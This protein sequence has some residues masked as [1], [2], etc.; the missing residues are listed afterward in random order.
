MFHL[1]QTRSYSGHYVAEAMDWMTGQW[2][3]FNDE[4][5]T[6]LEKGPSSSFDP[7]TKIPDSLDGSKDAYNLY[8]VDEAFLA[9]SVLEVFRG[10]ESAA[11]APQESMAMER[12]AE[13]ARMAQ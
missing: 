3:E 9:Q 10:E 1:N 2:F 5:V 7:A 4:K 13:Y 11:V 8:Y 12:S 6:F